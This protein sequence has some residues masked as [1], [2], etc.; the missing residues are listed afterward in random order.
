[1]NMTNDGSKG[2]S[3]NVTLSPRVSGSIRAVREGEFIVGGTAGSNNE[4]GVTLGQMWC[5][6]LKQGEVGKLL[7]NRTFTPPSTAGNLTISA[8][9]VDVDNMMFYFSE[10]K[11]RTRWGFSLETGQ[12][13]WKSNP[14]SSW[15]YYGMSDFIYEDKFFGI[16]AGNAGGGEL[17]AYNAKTGNIEWVY[18]ARQEG[19][20]SPY[21]NYPISLACITSDGKIYTSTSEHSPTQP[22]WRGSRIR[23]INATNGEEIWTINN[24]GAVRAADGLLV[25]LNMYDGRIYCYGKGPSATTVLIQNDVIPSGVNVLVKGTVTD[26]SAGGKDTPAI[27]D[28]DM[29]A[30]MEYTYMQQA[31]PTNAQGVSVHVTSIDP[32]GNFQDL[33]TVTTDDKGQYAVAWKPP[34]PGLYKV[35]ATF[36]GSKSYYGSEA[37]T[38]FY[39]SETTTLPFVSPE[40]TTTPTLP[41]TTQT[42]VTPQPASPT[43]AV[44]PSTS[45]P[46]TETY[47]AIGAV[48]VIVIVAVAAIILRRKKQ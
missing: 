47:V 42:P 22:L 11:T 1:M 30:W 7:W 28:E 41:P 19:F 21:G 39:V 14:E 24:W 45:A 48:V 13:V 9:N 31:K 27:A 34:V 35:T 12:Q 18:T 2:F 26:Q 4:D 38:T 33:G 32:N 29:T 23:C 20:E 44:E 10:T 40:V 6:S 46:A 37:E 5:L 15:N 36:A 8:P 43:P 25:A 3:Q 17:I 16:G